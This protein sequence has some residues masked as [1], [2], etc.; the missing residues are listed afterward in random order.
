[1][2]AVATLTAC[3]IAGEA[4]AATAATMATKTTRQKAWIL[5]RF[6]NSP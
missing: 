2:A 3:A 4:N 5:L 6:M 1:L